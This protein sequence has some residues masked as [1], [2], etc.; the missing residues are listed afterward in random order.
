MSFF[1]GLLLV[2]HLFQQL[3]QI[4][5]VLKHVLPENGRLKKY[6][7]QKHHQRTT[8]SMSIDYDKSMSHKKTT[9]GKTPSKFAILS[10]VKSSDLRFVTWLLLG[11]VAKKCSVKK[12]FLEISQNSQENISARVT[13]FFLGLSP[14]TL[15]KKRI[16]H[17]CFPLN[18]VK[19][20]RTPFLTE[21]LWWLLLLIHVISQV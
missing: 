3:I 12:V 1:L 19:F 18:F 6:G 21:H 4:I 11:T 9:S 7:D 15:L 10:H 16:R 20:L 8:M 17:R 2:N 5:L 14:A 13:F